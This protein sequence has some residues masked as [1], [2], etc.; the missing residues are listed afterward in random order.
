[1]RGHD[2]KVLCSKS[3]KIGFIPSFFENNH[4]HLSWYDISKLGIME[5]IG[6]LS[7]KII[8]WFWYVTFQMI[9]M[10]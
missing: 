5:Q 4:V 3:G 7:V 9:V 10:Q 8:M 6:A 2:R 1:M